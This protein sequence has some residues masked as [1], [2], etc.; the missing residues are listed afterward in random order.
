MLQI[1]F[2]SGS[3]L[4]VVHP[5]ERVQEHPTLL[6]QLLVHERTLH[7]HD[8]NL[9]AVHYRLQDTGLKLNAKKSICWVKELHCLGHVIFPSGIKPADDTLKCIAQ[10]LL[11]GDLTMLRSLLGLA[12]YYW[13]LVPQSSTVVKPLCKLVKEEV[14]LLWGEEQRSPFNKVK[15]LIQD[16]VPLAIF[17]SN[18]PTIVMTGVSDHGFGAV[19]QQ[20]KHCDGVKTV[21]FASRALTAMELNYF[22][23]EEE[24]LACSWVCER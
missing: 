8:S 4:D 19:L 5:T 20:Q 3:V 16:Y 6:G 17:D 24:T 23:G 12:S 13:K 18:L 2:G 21:Y 7:E 22:T 9:M 10:A 11:P 15:A 14:T 1:S